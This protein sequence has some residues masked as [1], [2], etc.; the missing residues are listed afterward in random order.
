MEE[1]NHDARYPLCLIILDGWGCSD[2]KEGN[3]ILAADTPN[4]DRLIKENPHTL[5]NASG[6][7]VGLP[8]GQMGNSEVGHLNIGAGRIVYQELTKISRSIELGK[9]FEKEA[10]LEAINNVNKNNSSLHL[11]GLLSDGGVHSHISHLKAL[12]D[13]A[14]MHNVRKLYL[15]AFLDGRDVPP[16]CALSYIE[17]ITAYMKDKGLGELAT[18]SGRY[19][20]MDR[21]NRW[22]RVKKAYDNLVY[23]SGQ[24]FGSAE[25]LL[26][27]SYQNNV[28][29]EFVIPASVHVSDHENAKIKS[30][31]SIIFFNF[32]PDRAREITRAFIYEDF[33]EFDRG[34]DVPKDIIFVCM[35]EYDALFGSARNVFIAYPP[36]NITNTLGEVISR[37]NLKQLRI[38]ETEKYAHVTFFLNGG[39]EEPNPGEDRIL[40][41][42]PKIAT[43]NLK[44]EMSAY[45]ITETVLGKIDE[46]SYHVIIV[47]FA[48]PDMVGHTGFFE[49]TLKAIEVV[50][51]CLGRITDKLKSVKGTCIMTADHGNAEEMFNLERQ[52][53]M[54]AHSNSRVPFII[55]DERIKSLVPCDNNDT[56]LCDISPTILEMLN[57]KKPDEMTGKSLI[58][59]WKNDTK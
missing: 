58:K 55:C 38:A 53:A 16:R 43:Y 11:F 20:A 3:A 22:D 51:E 48:N 29:D 45:E 23:R 12:I 18:I 27:S 2:K 9:F 28:D 32:R 49:Q 42:S 44:P 46:K 52:C 56:A 37:N 41:P 24:L 14:V 57:I 36:R 50:D 25:E 47:N 5:L 4:Y 13:L 15:H 26:A 54:T 59:E 30:K 34:P 31:D 1:N 19:Y 7:S 21:D 33:N 39:V 17:E 8:E 6:L 40:I 35:T 10:F